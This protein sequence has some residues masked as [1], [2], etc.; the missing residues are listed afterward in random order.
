MCVV[1]TPGVGCAA[2]RPRAGTAV[3]ALGVGLSPAVVDPGGKVHAKVTL[4]LAA[5]VIRACEVLVN[6]KVAQQTF[7]A[8]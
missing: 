4:G 1:A 6:G 2:G 3:L 8:S 7:T 5:R